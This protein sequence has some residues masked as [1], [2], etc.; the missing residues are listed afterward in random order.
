[1][2]VPIILQVLS[3]QGEKQLP[4]SN[5]QRH[6]QVNTSKWTLAC[7]SLLTYSDISVIRSPPEWLSLC[8]RMRVRQLNKGLSSSKS[9]LW[10]LQPSRKAQNPCFHLSQ[11]ML[12]VGLHFRAYMRKE[13]FSRVVAH[14]HGQ[15]NDLVSFSSWHGPSLIIGPI[16]ANNRLCTLQQRS[17][18]EVLALHQ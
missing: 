7:M 1:M 3:C 2:S 11:A 6:K 15:L 17:I 4:C 10:L 13:P 18:S 5:K 8:S 12:P 14:A 9:D 16:Y